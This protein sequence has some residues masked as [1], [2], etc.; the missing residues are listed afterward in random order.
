[1]RTV[2]GDGEADDR[3][4]V[5]DDGSRW[6]DLERR[7][8]LPW[9]LGIGAA[10]LGALLV[11]CVVKV[12]VPAFRETVDEA[13]MEAERSEGVPPES[14]ARDLAAVCA[15]VEGPLAEH[16]AAPDRFAGLP[17]AQEVVR[18]LADRLGALP[19]VQGQFAYRR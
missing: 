9:L 14:V 11:G 7:S 15:E 16:V 1:M 19:L 5:D 18:I 2:E 12:G 10:L 6:S 4:R 8:R 17:A 13:R 3:W